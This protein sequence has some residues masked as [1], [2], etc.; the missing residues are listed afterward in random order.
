MQRITDSSLYLLQIQKVIQREYSDIPPE[1][2]AT[3]EKVIDWVHSFLC[4]PHSELGRIGSVC[5]F[6][7]PSI[8]KNMFWLSVYNKN[9]IT[10]DQVYDAMMRFR[11]TFLDLQS[12]YDEESQYYLTILTLFPTISGQDKLQMMGA[13]KEKLKPDF[14]REG[15]MIGLFYETYQK[16]GLWNPSFKPF[17]SPV[18]MLVIRKIIPSDLYFSR[19]KPEYVQA[20]LDNFAPKI[21]NKI[22]KWI[23]EVIHKEA[24]RRL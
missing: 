20:Y 15:L 16:P 12:N 14:I 22:R 1:D 17:Q 13:L 7:Q 5:P 10:F 11:Q 21:P 24:L 23:A 6:T 18:P 9:F 8:H 19:N 4:N 2:I 3:I